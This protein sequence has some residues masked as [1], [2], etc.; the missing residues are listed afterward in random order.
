MK[1]GKSVYMH[2]LDGEP[3]YF[4]YD[5]QVCYANTRTTVSQLFVDDL[6]TIRRQWALSEAWRKSANFTP[7]L[8]E[9]H[10]LRFKRG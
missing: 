4:A 8:H 7:C 9:H 2:T 10:Y 3:A 5:E 1:Q 6:K